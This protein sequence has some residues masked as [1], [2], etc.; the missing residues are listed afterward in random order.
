MA[1][2]TLT[3]RYR[4]SGEAELR[5]AQQGAAAGFER[6]QRS[7][8]AA[9]GS[10][11]SLSAQI[12]GF[13]GVLSALAVALPI[14]GVARFAAEGLAAADALAKLSRRLSVSTEEM[15]AYRRAAELSG[16][17]GAASARTRARRH[18]LIIR[19]APG[20]RSD[21]RVRPRRVAA[22]RI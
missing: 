18:G 1:E 6:V 22:K 9:H 19:A 8:G 20:G 3:F 5:R 2:H 12:T 11:R 14:R 17:S 10:L 15:A 21:P 4:A 16:W 7:A 13:P